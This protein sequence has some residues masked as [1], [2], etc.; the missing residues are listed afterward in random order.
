MMG[1]CLQVIMAVFFVSLVFFS[2]VFVI[3]EAQANSVACA[4]PK[5]LLFSFSFFQYFLYQRRLL[6][7]VQ[8]SHRATTVFNLVLIFSLGKWFGVEDPI[9]MKLTINHFK[10]I[11]FQANPDLTVDEKGHDTCLCTE[12]NDF[13]IHLYFR[14][15]NVNLV[16]HLPSQR[17]A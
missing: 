9:I 8:I 4:T 13:L 5:Q 1:E 3:S 7:Y 14:I 16:F 6:C 17:R 2:S 12:F 15:D 10:L 11:S